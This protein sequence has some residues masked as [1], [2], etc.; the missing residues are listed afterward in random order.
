[1]DKKGCS[2]ARKRTDA[3]CHVRCI[4]YLARLHG[5]PGHRIAR[6]QSDRGF[7]YGVVLNYGPERITIW[8]SFKE[9]IETL[10]THEF[11]RRL[12]CYDPPAP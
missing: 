11:E 2:A 4:D 3:D 9:K 8:D 5:T 12:D 6:F 10:P 1:V 7:D